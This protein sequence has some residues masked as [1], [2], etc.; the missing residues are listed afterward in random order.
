MCEEGHEGTRL[1]GVSYAIHATMLGH[2]GARLSGRVCANSMRASAAR[3]PPILRT[4]I[5]SS[6]ALSEDSRWGAPMPA[7]N[8]LRFACSAVRD[9]SPDSEVGEP[10]RKPYNGGILFAAS[11]DER[12]SGML[13]MAYKLSFGLQG[14]KRSADAG[15]IGRSRGPHKPER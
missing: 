9:L 11:D 1:T 13:P 2:R 5:Q 10:I 12:E 7:E 15:Q 6:R 3:R 4:S 8:N 14:Q